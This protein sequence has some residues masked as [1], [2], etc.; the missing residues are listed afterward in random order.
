MIL[1][2]FSVP[3]LQTAASGALTDFLLRLFAANPDAEIIHLTLHA[4]D[5]VALTDMLQSSLTSGRGVEQKY[6]ML[7][8]GD[9]VQL[10]AG[11][12]SQS[13]VDAGWEVQAHVQRWRVQQPPTG[14]NPLPTLGTRAHAHWS[15]HVPGN[16]ISL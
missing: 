14:L 5:F 13:E 11:R 8:D 6:Y 2:R 7:L 3:V 4:A 12:P 9:A 10:S 16:T 15:A 1:A